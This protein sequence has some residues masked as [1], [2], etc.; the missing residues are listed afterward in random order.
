MVGRP[1]YYARYTLARLM[2]SYRYSNVGGNIDVW[3]TV[4]RRLADSGKQLAS[5]IPSLVFPRVRYTYLRRAR[6]THKSV[7]KDM[8][9]R[10]SGLP[11]STHN[12]FLRNVVNARH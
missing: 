5:Y 9:G 8:D 4:G 6:N 3:Q 10:K 7:C 12:L 1:Q 2:W 11:C